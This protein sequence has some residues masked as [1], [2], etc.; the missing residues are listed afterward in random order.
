MKRLLIS[1]AALSLMGAPAAFAQDNHDHDRS[2]WQ[3]RSSGGQQQSSQ[4]QSSQQQ[5]SQ[6]P[7]GQQ[8]G[9]WQGRSTGVTQQQTG[10]RPD[11]NAYYR[12]NPDLQ[13]AYRQ[14]QQSPTYHESI[15]T[16]AQRHYQEHG[17][18]EG[19]A[20]PTAQG[21]STQQ[22]NRWQG[23]GT[24]NRWQGRGDNNRYEGQQRWQGG[25]R[26]DNR[27]WQGGD[28]QHWGDRSVSR[29]WR[30]YERNIFAQ[31]RYR[32]GTYAWPRGYGYRR[33][34][35]GE[36][37]PE[38]FFAQDYWIYDYADYGLP[39]PPPGTQWVRYG[40]D[41]LLIDQDTGEIV[42]VIYSVFY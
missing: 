30:R 6:Q 4:Q 33:F 35:F 40:P 20:L 24:D 31:H 12:N 8:Q 39:F 21:Q 13:R 38:I 37:L 27:S 28:R 23:G 22:D 18:A 3:G 17:R 34:T 25:D 14:N 16:F 41:A 7:S 10:G 1:A 9:Q 5:S 19:R 26:N 29:D 36:Y 15:E 11:W 32:L 2:Q 42:Q